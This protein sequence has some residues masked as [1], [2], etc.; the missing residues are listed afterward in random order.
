GLDRQARE[1]LAAA[2]EPGC[3]PLILDQK[4]RRSLAALAC[5]H[6]LQTARRRGST[7]LSIV[8]SSLQDL[9]DKVKQM[10]GSLVTSPAN[11]LKDP[12]GVYFSS[13]TQEKEPQVAFLFP[14]QGSQQVDMLGD[15]TMHFS[16]VH[17]AIAAG[18]RLLK[19]KFDRALSAYIY[20]P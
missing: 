10:L 1:L 8:A 17:E 13:Q 2:A 5:F 16:E 14:G 7:R 11:A 4:H 12:R 9:R 19:G 20:P 15:L 6:Y 3:S 18:D